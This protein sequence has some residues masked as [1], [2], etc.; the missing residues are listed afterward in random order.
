MKKGTLYIISAPSGAGKSTLLNA[1]LADANQESFFSV[2]HTTR[3]PRVGEQDTINYHFVTHEQFLS[4][5]EKDDFIEY[6]KVFEQYYGTS[7]TMIYNQL[8]QGKNVF[9]DIDWQGA[10]QVRKQI[11]EAISIFIL[12]P[13]IAILEK[14]LRNRAQDNEETINKRMSEA[15][16]EISHYH[17]YDYVILNDDLN[18]AL[19]EF[20]AI[21]LAESLKT[22]KRELSL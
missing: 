7:K 13:S 12:P 17:E 19:K 16:N 2:S 14:R 18:M 6:A 1:Y 11:P 22:N 3:K 15:M 20:K 4:M 8:N 5:I 21:L 9:L 10:K